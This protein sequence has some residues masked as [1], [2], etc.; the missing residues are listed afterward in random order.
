ML[1]EILFFTHMNSPFLNLHENRFDFS[2]SFGCLKSSRLSPSYV[3][4]LNQ[5]NN[6]IDSDLYAY[7]RVTSSP[8]Q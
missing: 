7:E 3:C 6:I 5:E 2:I 4:A 1:L 8:S